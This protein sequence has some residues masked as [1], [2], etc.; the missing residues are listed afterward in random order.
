MNILVQV[1]I[2]LKP[3][4][5]RGL[6]LLASEGFS[7]AYLSSSGQLMN[8]RNERAATVILNPKARLPI[9]VYVYDPETSSKTSAAHPQR[10]RQGTGG[11]SKEGKDWGA[12]WEKIVNTLAERTGAGHHQKLTEMYFVCCHS[13][14]Y[15]WKHKF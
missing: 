12:G 13:L 4:I 8:D 6:Q 3:E 7:L 9:S 11:G 1:N 14:P 5:C 10:N 2:R 15:H